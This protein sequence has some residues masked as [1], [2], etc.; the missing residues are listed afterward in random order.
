MHPSRADRA[1]VPNSNLSHHLRRSPFPGNGISQARDRSAEHDSLAVL[2]LSGDR[3]APP[4]PTNLGLIRR[5]RGNLR[6]RESAWW[7]TQS[8]SNPSPQLASHL[9]GKRTAKCTDF[10]ACGVM[11][12][13]EYGGMSAAMG[14]ASLLRFTNLLH[15]GMVIVG[16]DCGHAGQMTLN[17]I[18][19]GS[20]TARPQLLGETVRESLRPTNSRERATKVARSRRPRKSCTAEGILRWA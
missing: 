12:G 15:F 8:T 4:Q 5:L 11:R 13:L 17:E 2:G 6:E 19:G 20:P 1:V 10:T 7:W 3:T 9:S 18:T 16:L 14:R